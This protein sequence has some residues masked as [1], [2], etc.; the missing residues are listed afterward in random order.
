VKY[1]PWAA[2]FAILAIALV[3]VTAVLLPQ[4]AL[5]TARP[6]E[7]W[8][9][10]AH[11]LGRPAPPLPGATPPAATGTESPR[12]APA[13]ALYVVEQQS[14]I[15]ASD[16]TLAEGLGIESPIGHFRVVLPRG[17][18]I[19]YARSVIFG[20]AADDQK[21][22]RLHVLRG[23]SETIAANHS[24]GWVRVP[25]LPPGPR[26]STRVSIIFRVVDG[27]VVLVAQNVADGRLLSIEASEAPP[28]FHR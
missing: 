5:R 25:D 14:P 28:G 3:A 27:A 15:V 1:A 24:L 11:P 2:G 9:E 18:P 20:T 23:R 17:T 7:L 6:A 13:P 8:G 19:R 21:E 22:I 12:T 26:G 4:N 10:L 16:Q